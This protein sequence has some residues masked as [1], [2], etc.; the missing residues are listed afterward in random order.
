MQVN[1]VLPPPRTH[2]EVRRLATR[3]LAIAL[4]VTLVALL[5]WI[6][7]RLFMLNEKSGARVSHYT[8]LR[9]RELNSRR[10]I[11]SKLKIALA[12]RRDRVETFRF[13]PRFLRELGEVTPSGIHLERVSVGAGKI[14]MDGVSVS[15]VGMTEL[16]NNLPAI[17]SIA[18]PVPMSLRNGVSD[19]NK[20]GEFSIVAEMKTTRTRE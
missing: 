5:T 19:G 1:L 2:G 6:Y 15:E 9:A 3:I 12:I 10:S 20:T 17:T 7:S 11:L 16:I 14:Q 13:G 8:D 4:S 18:N